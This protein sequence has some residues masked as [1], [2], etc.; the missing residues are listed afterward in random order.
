M[1]YARALGHVKRGRE[2][3]RE[4]ERERGRESKARVQ[5][6]ILPLREV[7]TKLR[8]CTFRAWRGEEMFVSSAGG[9]SYSSLTWFKLVAG[10]IH[11]L[12]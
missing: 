9:T 10:F 6:L 4:R 12:Q 1:H 5:A 11:K 7:I 8:G 2:R 3:E